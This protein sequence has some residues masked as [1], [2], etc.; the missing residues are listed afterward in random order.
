MNSSKYAC[1]DMLGSIWNLKNKEHLLAL[2]HCLQWMLL[3]HIIVAD[4]SQD[5]QQSDPVHGYL[6]GFKCI[7]TRQLGFHGQ[8]VLSNNQMIQLLTRWYSFLM[9]V[10]T[11]GS[12]IM[13]SFTLLSKHF[14]SNREAL[15]GGHL[16]ERVLAYLVRWLYDSSCPH[17][18]NSSQHTERFPSRS[19]WSCPLVWLSC[20]QRCGPSTCRNSHETLAD[21][22][23]YDPCCYYSFCR[24]V[25]LSWNV[26]WAAI[27]RLACSL[28][29]PELP[30]PSAMSLCR[31]STTCIIK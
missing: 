20:T 18:W 25:L 11:R 27:H 16:V 9:F 21:G 1:G 30:V 17:P 26:P 5:P 24:L 15:P 31:W 14:C 19:C 28:P 6:D 23:H 22:S 29:S 13:Y 12:S 4:G 10:F 8:C 7:I 3:T 2:N